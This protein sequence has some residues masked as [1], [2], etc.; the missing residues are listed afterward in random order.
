MHSDFSMMHERIAYWVARQAGV[1]ASRANHA[2]VTVNGQLYGLYANVETVKK[3]I[4]SRVFGNNTG[5]LFSATD[6]DFEAAV[7]PDLRAGGRARRS[8]AARR[9]WRRR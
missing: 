3:H 4:L 8:H 9:A 1:P 7:H 5:S 2:L 6:V